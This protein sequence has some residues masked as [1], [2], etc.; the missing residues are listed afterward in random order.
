MCYNDFTLNKYTKK[1]EMKK[2]NELSLEA[3]ASVSDIIFNFEKLSD[4]FNF[5]DI[6]DIDMTE[7]EIELE[8]QNRL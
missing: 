6:V 8:Y 4:I 2:F 7:E 1:L 5:L 3:Q